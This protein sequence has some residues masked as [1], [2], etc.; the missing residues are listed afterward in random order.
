MLVPQ[1]S[2]QFTHSP[3]SKEK[4]RHRERCEDRRL[5]RKTQKVRE[6]KEDARK[7]KGLKA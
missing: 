6:D 1:G 4:R 7:S 3:N 2:I 5:Q